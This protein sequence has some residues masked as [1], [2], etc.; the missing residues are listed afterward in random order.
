MKCLQFV[1]EHLVEQIVERRKTPS[2]C[3]LE[4]VAIDLDDYNSALVV[5]DYYKVYDSFLVNKC[6]IRILAMELWRWD[7]IPG[8]LW[9][10]E[11]NTNADGCNPSDK[12]NVPNDPASV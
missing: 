1:S 2:V 3:C 5:G 6:T 9:R 8:R 4:E 7:N 12:P 10:G 11:T